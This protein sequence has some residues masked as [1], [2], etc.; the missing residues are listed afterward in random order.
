MTAGTNQK[1]SPSWRRSF[2]RRA[3]KAASCE[4]SSDGSRPGCSRIG[5][6]ACGGAPGILLFTPALRSGPATHL[7]PASTG[8]NRRQS[9]RFGRANL[10][11]RWLVGPAPRCCA[12]RG[13]HGVNGQR[14]VRIGAAGAFLGGHP[15][16]FHYFLLGGAR[17]QRR[18]RVCV[19]CVTTTAI[20]CLVFP[21]SAPSPNTAALKI[22]KASSAAR[23]RLTA[24]ARDLS[25]GCWIKGGRG[26]VW[27][28]RSNKE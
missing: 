4:V 13:G 22:L 27:P 19:T 7:V 14:R 11:G 28:K 2:R 21:G 10:H 1:E 26:T 9:N 8:S 25:G 23:V 20:N 24:L 15:D 12:A 16:G 17:L 3:V 6:V 5:L 18:L